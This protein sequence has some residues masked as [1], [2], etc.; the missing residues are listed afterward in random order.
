MRIIHLGKVKQSRYRPEVPRGFQEVKISYISWQRHTIVVRLSDL[1]TGHFYPQEILLVLISVRRWV[2]HRAIVRS[3]GYVNKKFQW[4][5]L[6]IEPATFQ[7]IAQHLSHCATAVPFERLI[8]VS[9]E[10]FVAR[11]PQWT[12]YL[13]T[14]SD[15]LPAATAQYQHVAIT[16]RSRQLLKIG[17]WLPETCWATCKV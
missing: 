4:H 6:G 9:I 1:R 11:I 5:Q 16:L 12:H 13:L 8:H 14:S 15:S 10:E 17:T 2:D 7:F 3:E